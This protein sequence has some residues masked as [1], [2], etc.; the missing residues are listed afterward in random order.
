MKLKVC[1]MKYSQNIEDLASLNPDF[2]GFIFYLGS[3]RCADYQELKDDIQNLDQEIKRV[4]VFV[5]Q[6]IPEVLTICDELHLDYAQLHGNESLDFITELKL[7]GIKIIKVFHIDAHFNWNKCK[8]FVGLSDYFL[9]DTACSNYG[10]S[11]KQFDWT[12]LKEYKDNLPFL[13]SGGIDLEHLSIIKELQ[14]PYLAG[15]D[16]N[17]RFEFATGIKDLKK[18]QILKNKLTN[19]FEISRQ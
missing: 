2:M 10:G 17:S 16:V 9:F 4:G 6:A 13:L 5:N 1:G 14:L 7:S 18:L 3:K 8:K 15:I 19:E 11:G 12:L